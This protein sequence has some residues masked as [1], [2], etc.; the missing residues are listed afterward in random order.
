ML[1]RIISIVQSPFAELTQ[2]SRYE[3]GAVPPKM[4]REYI[5]EH[6]HAQHLMSFGRPLLQMS[7]SVHGWPLWESSCG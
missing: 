7:V 3:S 2:I 5:S 4:L 6:P 1:P